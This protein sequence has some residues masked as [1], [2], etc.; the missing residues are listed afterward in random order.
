MTTEANQPIAPPPLPPPRLPLRNTS[1]GEL[2]R[3]CYSAARLSRHS[4][5]RDVSD[6]GVQ[7]LRQQQN[8]Q[9]QHQ[10]NMSQPGNVPLFFFFFS[11]LLPDSPTVGPASRRRGILAVHH[12]HQHEQQEFAR[13]AGAGGLSRCSSRP[14]GVR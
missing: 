5:R 12:R 14:F 3:D 2:Q 11:V 13:D 4:N 1:T 8:H 7:F 10:H 9:H 6:V